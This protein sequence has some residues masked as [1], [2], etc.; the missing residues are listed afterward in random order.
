MTRRGPGDDT[1]GGDS[2]EPAAD[3]NPVHTKIPIAGEDPLRVFIGGVHTNKVAETVVIGKR[4]N[5]HTANR[6]GAGESRS[7]IPDGICFLGT[8]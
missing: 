4:D 2:Q 5:V 8:K 7:G 1:V 3:H 6:G